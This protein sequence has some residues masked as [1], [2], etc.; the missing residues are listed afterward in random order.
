MLLIHWTKQ[1][2]TNDIIKNGI[3]P[4]LRKNEDNPE[5][6]LKGVWCYPYTRTKTLNNHWKQVL[7]RSRKLNTNFNGF[8][9]KLEEEDFPLYAGDFGLIRFYG[10]AFK[11]NNYADFSKD[12]GHFFSEKQIHHNDAGIDYEDFEI[13]IPRRIEA[14]RII[15]IIKER[16]TK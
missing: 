9:F 11:I 5:N 10:D 15:K 16:P 6:S 2:N 3:K 1:N 13:I 14:K 7:K 12:Y 4:N 8:V